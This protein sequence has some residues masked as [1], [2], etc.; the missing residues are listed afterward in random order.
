MAG[1]SKYANIKHR[2]G[3]QDAKRAKMFAKLSREI[4]VAAK[5]GMPDPE[6]NPRL[7]NAV[8]EARSL[9]MPGDRIKKAIESAT[10]SA[11]GENFEEVRY[12]GYGV[13]GVAVIVE[14]LTD[15]R[16]RT[17]AEV[18][19]AFAKNGGS[20]GE[21]NSVSFMFEKVGV[22]TYPTSITSEDDIFEKA[23]EAGADN[24]ETAGDVYE[25]TTTIENF[26]TVRDALEKEFKDP[27]S[28]AIIWKPNNGVPVSE[29][30]A[31][32]L[33]KMID[34]LEDSDDVQNVYAN[35]DISDEIMEKLA[36]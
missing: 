10:A 18:R 34:S 11:D 9:S 14:A 25:I 19:T 30:H 33:F 22:V 16:N 3:A 35:F 15:N 2:K 21:T 26:I 5:M 28:A 17:A 29:D 4:M 27:T 32:T 31:E 24:V 12:E 6:F 20:L 7:R 23:V 1:H 8:I 13:G 36:G